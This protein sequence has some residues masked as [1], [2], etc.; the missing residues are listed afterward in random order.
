MH[1]WNYQWQIQKP[2]QTRSETDFV[3]IWPI[4]PNIGLYTVINYYSNILTTRVSMVWSSESK[5]ARTAKHWYSE[6][7]HLDMRYD[8]TRSYEHDEKPNGQLVSLFNSSASWLTCYRMAR[9]KRIKKPVL[10]DIRSCVIIWFISSWWAANTYKDGC[11]HSRFKKRRIYID[12]IQC[13]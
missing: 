7:Y 3:Q 11:F 13:R 9:H 2:R 12:K 4:V 5:G 6:T 1:T 10:Y 8:F